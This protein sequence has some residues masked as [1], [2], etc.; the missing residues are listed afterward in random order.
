MTLEVLKDNLGLSFTSMPAVA[1]QASL[2]KVD[3]GTLNL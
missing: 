3:V 1:A 2:G